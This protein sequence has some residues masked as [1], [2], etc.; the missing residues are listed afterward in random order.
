M[1]FSVNFYHGG[2]EENLFI[3]KIY[4][5]KIIKKSDW[6]GCRSEVFNGELQ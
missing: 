5:D 6:C 1:L 3:K 2:S 4:D